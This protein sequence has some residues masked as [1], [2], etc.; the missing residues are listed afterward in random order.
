MSHTLASFS[1]I[2]P[3][4]FCTLGSEP[5]NLGENLAQGKGIGALQCFPHHLDD[6]V[7]L[8]CMNGMH[9]YA[10]RIAEGDVD[11]GL[12]MKSVHISMDH[13]V[14]LTWATS[15]KSASIVMILPLRMAKSSS[16]IGQALT[17][18]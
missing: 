5:D 4:L 7:Q 13:F 11:G 2:W 14:E 8:Y 9:I 18:P 17:C 15:S 12:T 1:D 6:L 10:T 16:W 3:R